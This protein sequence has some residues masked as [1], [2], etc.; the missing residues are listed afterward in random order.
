M[1]SQRPQPP[2]APE[3]AMDRRGFLTVCGKAAA[4]FGALALAGSLAACGG[5]AEPDAAQ[6]ASGGASGSPGAGISPSSTGSPAPTG[7]AYYLAHKDELVADASQFA[8]GLEATMVPEYGKKT[9]AAIADDMVTDFGEILNE[10]PYIGGDENASM[11]QML[12]RC[13]MSMAFCQAMLEN[14]KTVDDAGRINYF[15]LAYVAKAHPMPESERYHPTDIPKE[16]REARAWATWSQK[17]EYPD[18][19]V[20]DY[21]GGLPKPYS[22]GYDYTQCANMI[23]CKHLGIPQFTRYLC[24]IDVVEFGETGQ[25]ITRTRTIAGGFDMCDFYFRTDGVVDIK[26]P[27]TVRKLREWGV[28]R[29]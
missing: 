20:A 27:F 13:S 6:S 8:G 10:L 11:T 12:V 28:T 15:A 22:Y 4:A 3:N 23:V 26:E 29:S 24:M 9:A 19:W 2:R 21:V 5:K 18:G 14:G 25:G 17:R 16:R 1:Q 7:S